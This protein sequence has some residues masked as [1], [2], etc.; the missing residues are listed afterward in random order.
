[1]SLRTARARA[2]QGPTLAYPKPSFALSVSPVWD[3]VTLPIA[4]WKNPA[5]FGEG[6]PTEDMRTNPTCELDVGIK[7]PDS[8]MPYG[9]KIVMHHFVIQPDKD[10]VMGYYPVGSEP[11]HIT[12]QQGK[13]VRDSL[14]TGR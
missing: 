10:N 1:M 12:L 3:I 14:E 9:F 7:V 4:W 2:V 6:I 11:N 8:T 5:L 13:I